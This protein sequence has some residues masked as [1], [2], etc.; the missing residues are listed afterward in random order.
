[1]RFAKELNL[2]GINLLHIRLNVIN[3]L[4]RFISLFHC[5]R[6]IHVQND[7]ESENGLHPTIKKKLSK[8][9]ENNV[10]VSL[11]RN[12]FCSKSSIFFV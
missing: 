9:A 8:G 3:L 6:D 4:Q 11:C 2:M 1:M 12:F 7:G 5:M 10:N